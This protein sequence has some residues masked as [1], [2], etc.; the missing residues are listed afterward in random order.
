MGKYYF[1]SFTFTATIYEV[2]LPKEYDIYSTG[3]IKTGISRQ[4]IVHSNNLID[5]HPFDWQ[6]DNPDAVLG[7]W[8]EISEDIYS[9]YKGGE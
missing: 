9:K 1:I 3:S 6:G 5:I 8:K 7:N 2:P 4:E